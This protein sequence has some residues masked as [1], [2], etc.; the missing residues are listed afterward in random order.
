MEIIIA[1]V[2]I[3]VGLIW[4][5][6]AKNQPK[7]PVETSVPEAPKKVE[8]PKVPAEPL[9]IPVVQGT[10][11]GGIFNPVSLPVSLAETPKASEPAPAKKPRARKAAA[12]PATAATA[13]KKKAPAKKTSAKKKSA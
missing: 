5:F 6:N 7:K 13:K 11:A 9:T 1:L 10:S 4:Y 2:I 3:G 12:A 8:A